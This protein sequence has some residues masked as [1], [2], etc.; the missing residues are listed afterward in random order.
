MR[1]VVIRRLIV[2]PDQVFDVVIISCV[3]KGAEHGM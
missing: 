1:T 3:C 2:C